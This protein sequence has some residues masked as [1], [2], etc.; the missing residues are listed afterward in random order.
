VLDL[1]AGLGAVTRPL[2]ET[3]ARVIAVE[4]DE[5][6]AR[7]LAHR[8]APWPRVTVITGDAL[9]V[10]LPGRP[11]RVVASIPFAI[12]TALLRR[13]AGSRMV[14]AE[15]AVERGAG[16]RLA[17]SP[18]VRHELMSWHRRFAFSLGPVI[19]A[20]S[21]RPAPPVDAVVLRIHRNP[22][23]PIKD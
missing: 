14:A 1:G 15:L 10:P 4:R 16:R 2:A 21:F 12:T 13:L 19:P 22:R 18:P 20:R 6:I 8:M 3:G 23:A 11:Y 9:T 7:R 17:A 5:R